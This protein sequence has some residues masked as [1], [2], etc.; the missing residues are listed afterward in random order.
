[1]SGSM[2]RSILVTSLLAGTPLLALSQSGSIS[3]RANASSASDIQ[4][5]S[6]V[7]QA[8]ADE[9]RTAWFGSTS[10]KVEG[11]VVVLSFSGWAPRP[12]LVEAIAV[13]SRSL[14][15]VVEPSATDV[16]L[17]EADVADAQPGMGKEPELAIRLNDSGVAKLRARGNALLGRVVSIYWDD[18]LVSRPKVNAT[19]VR[20]ISITVPSADDAMLMAIVL[21]SGPL[22]KGTSL[23]L[24]R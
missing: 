12:K 6:K 24:V 7:L 14:R 1:M 11:N 18:R 23:T 17:T 10:A 13:S 5:I 16:L 3:I 8:R 20:D 22:P 9:L 15:L 19:L 21:R 2:R 4:A